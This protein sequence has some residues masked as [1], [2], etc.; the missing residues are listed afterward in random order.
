MELHFR[1]LQFSNVL[2]FSPM[3]D[4]LENG[5]IFAFWHYF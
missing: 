4:N 1:Y 5:I 3:N 2:E